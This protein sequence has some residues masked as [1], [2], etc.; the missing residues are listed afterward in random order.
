MFKYA[1]MDRRGK[2]N[3]SQFKY[4]NT[5]ERR[6]VYMAGYIEGISSIQQPLIS[7]EWYM[8]KW[9]VSRATLYND[10]RELSLLYPEILWTK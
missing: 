7:R 5:R 2:S 10:V 9:K 1:E 3:M 4:R 8:K 6:I